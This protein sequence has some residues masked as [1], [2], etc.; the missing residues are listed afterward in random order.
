[1]RQIDKVDDCCRV[2]VIDSC[3]PVTWLYLSDWSRL[4]TVSTCHVVIHPTTSKHV[5]FHD[6][7]Y[8]TAVI[9]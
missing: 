1:M 8:P 5:S 4:S 2:A 3:L 9:N 7:Y 6:S